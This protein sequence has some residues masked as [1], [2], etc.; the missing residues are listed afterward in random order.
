MY[1]ALES[2][3]KLFTDDFGT[4]NPLR[5]LRVRY[6]AI[7]ADLCMIAHSSVPKES[8]MPIISLSYWTYNLLHR[9]CSDLLTLALCLPIN[10]VP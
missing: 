7:S 8:E 9:I 10:G 1:I 3:Q 2:I 6:S 5:Q 4:S